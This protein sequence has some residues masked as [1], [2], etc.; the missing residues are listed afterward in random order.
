MSYFSSVKI[1]ANDSPS[2][3]AFGGWRVSNKDFRFDSQLTYG[4]DN[5][6]FWDTLT[7]GTATVAFNSNQRAAV[8]T[9]G[10]AANEY[11][12]L[13]SH[14]FPPYTPGRSQ[15]A[16]P[17]F[18]IGS[19]VPFIN[20][21]VGYFDDYNGVYL[22]QNGSGTLSINLLS[23]VSGSPVITSFT[24]DNWNKDTMDGSG[25]SGIDI[26]ATKIQILWIDA[27]VLY[28]G[29]VR[30]G[31]YV[32][33]KLIYFHEFNHA[34]VVDVPFVQSWNLPIR[35][36]IRNTA[37]S[38]G[39]SMLAVCA[40]VSS[41]GGGNLFEIPG[42]P[43]TADTGITPITVS[44]TRTPILSVRT[45][46]TFNSLLN[47]SIVVP[48]EFEVVNTGNNP[49]LVEIIYNGT[50][51]GSPSFTNIDTTNSTLQKDVAANSITGGSIIWSGYVFSS[52]VDKGSKET[53]IAEKV[54]LALG[55]DEVTQDVLTIC[56]TI[57]T[58][59]GAVYAS[60]KCREIR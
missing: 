56:G 24:Q 31:F 10:T 7:T 57:T 50:L 41:E 30:C 46:T 23:S 36:K 32:G 37:G 40:S 19:P 43:S 34:N 13:Q 4:I 55:A 33:G 58:G 8:L 51:G 53:G 49:V 6:Y 1:Q 44:T 35:Y 28:S 5:T 25:P 18:V 2:L 27:Q 39:G 48:V 11:A 3:D 52:A 12:V 42:I 54:V 38:A 26:N 21:Q 16:V 47:R 15:I 14:Y 60:I 59:T 45:R 20:K 22:Q 29:R 17:T 9:V